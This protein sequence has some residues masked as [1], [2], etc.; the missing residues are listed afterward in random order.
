MKIEG[1]SERKMERFQFYSR[2]KK[3]VKKM[4]NSIII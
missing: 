2:R 4:R 3:A 1:N